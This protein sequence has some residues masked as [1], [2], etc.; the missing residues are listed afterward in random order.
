[1]SD[2]R[3]GAEFMS[4]RYNVRNK[5]REIRRELKPLENYLLDDIAEGSINC[6]ATKREFDLND[7]AAGLGIR[8]NRVY[9][10]L[11]DLHARSIITREPTKYPCLEILGFNESYF[12]QILTDH[13]YEIEKK[14]THLKVIVDNSKV[15]VDNFDGEVPNGT[16]QVP[17]GTGSLQ[18]RDLSSPKRD[19]I[20]S[21]INEIIEESLPIDSSQ[22]DI[23]L[24]R[25]KY[26]NAFA[27][28]G[29]GTTDKQKVSS[30]INMLNLNMKKIRKI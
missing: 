27:P 14:K 11:K 3:K 19:L 23:E 24:L 9:S 4:L 5:R 7:L 20:S 26:G 8:V 16:N 17:N 2:E 1:M 28:W 21:Q 22:I 10:M 15:A 25:E 18:N 6:W 13:Q 12:G 29:P 30:I